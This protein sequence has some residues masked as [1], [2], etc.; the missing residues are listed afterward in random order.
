MTGDFTGFSFNGIHSSTLGIVRVSGGDRYKE[1]LQS[2]VRDKTVEI[3]GNDG[4]YYYWSTYGPRTHNIEIAFDS[5]TEVQFRQLRQLFSTKK[6]CEL[7]F[8]E[9]PY[10]VYYAKIESPIELNYICF[11]EYSKEPYSKKY[12]II[13][14]ENLPDGIRVV[15]RITEID[16]QTEE[17]TTTI[18]REKIDPWVVD[19]SKKQ[20]IYKGEGT[21][22]LV[23]H[24][25]F[26][27]Q[28]YRILDN[29]VNIPVAG[30]VYTNVDEWK[31]SSGI[32]D[33][34][35]RKAKQIDI[36]RTIKGP[37][38]YSY[39]I[40]VYNPGDLNVGFCL[41]IPFNEDGEIVPREGE[42]YIRIHGETNILLLNKIT[43]RSKLDTGIIINTTHH[44]IEGVNFAY[45]AQ[46]YD[47]RTPAWQTTGTLYND[48]IV[49]GDFPYIK[50]KDWNTWNEGTKWTDTSELQSINI[51]CGEVP[52]GKD[53]VIYYN[54]LYI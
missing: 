19:Y 53:I 39:S 16:E 49:A 1:E 41:Y 22:T 23:S 25:P 4:D 8:D 34:N 38:I 45:I 14:E 32:L 35:T 44:L 31:E 54:Y 28:L 27:K 30:V 26:A 9:R 24:Y 21:I 15:D 48:A 43:R 46:E 52:E 17:S 11:D 40:N 20:R 7:I 12:N 29:Y 42:T 36:T 33:D 13:Q 18:V 5:M 2:E 6:V 50:R 3:P 51:S 10:K 47:R 37:S